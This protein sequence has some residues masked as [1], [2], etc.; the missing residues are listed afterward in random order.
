MSDTVIRAVE[1]MA[2]CQGVKQL[3][4]THRDG[5][6]FEPAYYIAGVDDDSDDKEDEDDEYKSESNDSSNDSSTDSDSDSDSDFNSDDEGPPELVRRD[7]SQ[8]LQQWE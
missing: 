4:F 7:D 8:L 1:N 6:P 2:R 3:K 5:T